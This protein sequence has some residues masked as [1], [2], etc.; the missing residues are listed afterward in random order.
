MMLRSFHIENFKSLADFTL[1]DMGQFVCLIGLNGAGKTSLLQ[2]IDFMAHVASGSVEQW[3]KDRDWTRSDLI[4]KF[5]KK[6]LI[7]FRLEFDFGRTVTTVTWEGTYNVPLGRCTRESVVLEGS[8]RSVLDVTD[9]FVN[10]SSGQ[11]DV[12]QGDVKLDLSLFDYSGSTLSF[13]KSV[14]GSNHPFTRFK[15]F[16]ASIKSLELLAP[17]RMRLKARSADD[18]GAGGE[19]LS[20][21]LH[22]LNTKQKQKILEDLRRFYPIVSGLNT[23]ATRAG[24]AQLHATEEFQSNGDKSPSRITTESKHLND[25]MLR[26]LT[27]VAQTQTDHRFLLFDE[28]E[29]GINPEK[30]GQLVEYLLA[31]TQQIL[32]TTHN[33]L[34]L[35]Y[36]PDERAK[37]SVFLLYRNRH[38]VTKAVRFYE[39]PE[40]AKKLEVLGPGEAFLDTSLEELVAHLQKR[41]AAQV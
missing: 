7:T 29:N 20:G 32:V 30:I 12:K 11:E 41:G 24:L 40:V 35:N 37:Q 22:G 23:E 25:G 2:A 21:Y 26:I 6:Q 16:M 13:L 8:G 10:L 4:S 18:I 17:H 38:G 27:I 36:L 14:S 9:G 39:Q 1:N 34:I 3:L 19:K 28:I 31:A 33:P 5:S 15:Q